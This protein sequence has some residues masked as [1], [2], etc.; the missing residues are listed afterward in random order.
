[1]YMVGRKIERGEIVRYKERERKG[2][3]RDM[4]WLTHI[5]DT[6]W[7]TMTPTN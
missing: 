6:D 7:S 1:M 2:Y 3:K 4:P 5:A